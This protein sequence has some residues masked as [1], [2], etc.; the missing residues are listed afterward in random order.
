MADSSHKAKVELLLKNMGNILCGNRFL[1]ASGS[2]SEDSLERV[3]SMA[4]AIVITFA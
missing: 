4:L 3:A 2:M 1:L